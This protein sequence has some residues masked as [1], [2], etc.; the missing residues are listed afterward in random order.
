MVSSDTALTEGGCGIEVWISHTLCWPPKKGSC[1]RLLVRMGILLHT[2]WT[3]IP[4][5]LGEASSD[6]MVSSGL[7]IPRRWWKPLLPWGC[8]WQP[9]WEGESAAFQTSHMVS[10]EEAVSLPELLRTKHCVA[11]STSRGASPRRGWG[12]VQGRS[13]GSSVVIVAIT[14]IL[15][16][17][18]WTV[19]LWQFS[20]LLICIFLFLCH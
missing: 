16:T 9:H 17:V 18:C 15:V 13:L 3:L 20:A 19:T 14:M 1:A 5:W 12:A 2:R 7:V 8:L 11:T 6:T 10:Q 4:V